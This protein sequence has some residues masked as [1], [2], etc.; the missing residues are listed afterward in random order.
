MSRSAF[1][2]TTS[3]WPTRFRFPASLEISQRCR[4]LLRII[5]WV[6]YYTLISMSVIVLS[7]Q[8][9]SL[10]FCSSITGKWL[11]DFPHKTVRY[12]NLAWGQTAVWLMQGVPI[13]V[14]NKGAVKNIQI[15][16]ED[17]MGGRKHATKLS[18]VESFALNPDDLAGELQRKF[19]ASFA[20]H[21]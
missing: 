17:R 21:R 20:L 5:W 16:M 10:T 15:R 6:A 12:T 18:H 19:Q 8:Q 1:F 13:E 4:V 14:V 3:S 9:I 11:I 2:S 7:L